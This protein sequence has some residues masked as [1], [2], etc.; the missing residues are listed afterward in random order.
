MKNLKFLNNKYII[1][2][3]L[4][5]NFAFAEEEAIDIWN[6]EN[7]NKEN[8]S[9]EIETNT[10]QLI[11][12]S[13]INVGENNNIEFEILK[14]DELKTDK[15]NLVGLYDPEENELKIDMWSKTDGKNIKSLFTK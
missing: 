7:S 3:L 14:D 11:E 8:K 9:L 1:F 5:F 15:I 4:L 6:L 12:K 2:F 13:I 10:E